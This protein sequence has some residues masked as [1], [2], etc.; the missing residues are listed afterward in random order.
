MQ[1]AAR[2]RK[3]DG[4]HLRRA[5]G[6]FPR[7]AVGSDDADMRAEPARLPRAGG[8]I[9]A[10]RDAIAAFDRPRLMRDRAP[11]EDARR[12]VEDLLRGV[13]VERGRDHGADRALAEAPGGGGIRFRDLLQHLHEGF[14]R[15]FGAARFCGSSAR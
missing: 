14:R 6:I 9:P 13:V 8:K 12:R 15:R 2:D 5:V 1:H 3:Q 11:G 4:A 7:R 10:R